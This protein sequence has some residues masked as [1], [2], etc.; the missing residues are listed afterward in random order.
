MKSLVL[1][2]VQP[3]L[4]VRRSGDRVWGNT[5]KNTKN[6]TNV[7]KSVEDAALPRALLRERI[8]SR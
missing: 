1:L 6:N 4:P 2:V 8:V 7:I 3:L 5:T